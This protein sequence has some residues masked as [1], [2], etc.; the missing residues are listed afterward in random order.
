MLQCST[1]DNWSDRLCAI[2]LLFSLSS[3]ITHLF[4][5][6]Q[7]NT[8]LLSGLHDP[9]P[10]VVSISVKACKSI[11]T[12]LIIEK[13][14]DPF[15]PV[16]AAYIDLLPLLL[17]Q[18]NIDLLLLALSC[19]SDIANAHRLAPPDLQRAVDFS[20]TVRP[21]CPHYAQV[22]KNQALPAVVRSAVATFLIHAVEAYSEAFLRGN[23]VGELV[24]SSVRSLA[25]GVDPRG[26]EEDD[27][28]CDA[29]EMLLDA[30]G[31][32]LPERWVVGR[33]VEA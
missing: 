27:A 20:L 11:L 30:V 19:L 16:I 2:L 7:L 18:Q 1:S 14:I 33:A 23:C 10:E 31:C 12:S 9:H 3:H 5:T 25:E 21:H 6:P 26:E 32:F 8:L 17:S 15:Q 4:D 22:A 29:F 28:V 24:D 13:K